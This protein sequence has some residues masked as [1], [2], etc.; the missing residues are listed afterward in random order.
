[1]CKYHCFFLLEKNRTLFGTNRNCLEASALNGTWTHFDGRILFI[2]FAL[3][4]II[5]LIAYRLI[6]FWNTSMLRKNY[7][8]DKFIPKTYQTSSI[9]IIFDIIISTISKKV[10]VPVN[11]LGPK[12]AHN[13]QREGPVTL[14]E[15][16]NSTR[17][18]IFLPSDVA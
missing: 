1:M 4:K 5:M 12:R 10:N 2:F 17:K 6:I 7:C 13:A 18:Q 11:G 9:N 3:A 8:N 14:N 16:I 15:N